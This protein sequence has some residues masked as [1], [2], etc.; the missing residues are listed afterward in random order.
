MFRKRKT[1]QQKSLFDPELSISPIMEKLLQK[2]WTGK[3][4][5]NYSFTFTKNDFLYFTLK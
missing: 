1:A 3:F 4:F 5:Q 2:G